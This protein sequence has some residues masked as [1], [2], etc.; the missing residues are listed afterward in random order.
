MEVISQFMERA[1]NTPGM[2]ENVAPV[3]HLE[4][5]GRSS[6]LPDRPDLGVVAAVDRRRLLRFFDERQKGARQ[7]VS[8][9]QSPVLKDVPRRKV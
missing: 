8:Q 1:R 9:I 7:I 5:C 4:P 3:N 6:N 2:I